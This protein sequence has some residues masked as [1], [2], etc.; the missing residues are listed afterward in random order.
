MD[1]YWVVIMALIAGGLLVRRIYVARVSAPEERRSRDK[2]MLAI[3]LTY[4]LT[5]LSYE[6]IWMR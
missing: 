4:V 3:V 6:Y 2:V 5:S 1:R